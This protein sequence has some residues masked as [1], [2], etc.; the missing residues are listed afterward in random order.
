MTT[1]KA[2]I[3][4][5]WYHV[6]RVRLTTEYV[7]GIV[8]GFGLGLATTAY[9]M[10]HDAVREYW[11]LMQLGGLALIAIGGFVALYAQNR[12]SQH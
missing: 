5:K 12:Y 2:K 1:E 9:L 3:P 7:G 6:R 8:A 4:L 10:S 11:V